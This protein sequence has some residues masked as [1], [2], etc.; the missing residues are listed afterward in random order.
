REELEKR[1]LLH[2]I[3]LLK[4]EL[5]QRTLL[6]DTLRKEQSSQVEELREQLANVLHQRKMLHLKLKSSA[7]FHEQEVV[8]LKQMVR[9]LEERREE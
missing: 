2:R 3:E 1:Q 5:S 7:H 4:L 6:I 9:D 8:H